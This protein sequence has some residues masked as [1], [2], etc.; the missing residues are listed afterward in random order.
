MQQ[1]NCNI[2]VINPQ[3]IENS[4]LKN[5]EKE[6]LEKCCFCNRKTFLMIYNKHIKKMW[7]HKSKH[8]IKCGK[9]ERGKCKM[10][11][12]KREVKLCGVT[13]Q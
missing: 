11:I 3:S 1:K 13:Y 9:K 10:K 2:N 7:K 8:Y 12:I 6:I 4:M 5:V